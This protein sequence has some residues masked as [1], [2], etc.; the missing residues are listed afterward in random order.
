MD[1]KSRVRYTVC[2]LLIVA[3]IGNIVEHKKGP[4]TDGIVAI[5][6]IASAIILFIYSARR[7]N[8]N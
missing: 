6:A 8:G 7:A 4:V 2:V 1:T 5:L 3:A